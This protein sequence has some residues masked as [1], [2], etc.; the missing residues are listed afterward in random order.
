ML[1]DPK[2]S[3]SR[4]PLPFRR[5]SWETIIGLVSVILLVGIICSYLPSAGIV[6]RNV[7]VAS[8]NHSEH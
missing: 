1:Y 2:V 5:Q 4:W 3:Q 8:S 7:A 6:E